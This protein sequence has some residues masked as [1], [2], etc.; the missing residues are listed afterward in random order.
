MGALP[1]SIKGRE[2]K[3]ARTGLTNATKSDWIRKFPGETS[4]KW[5]AEAIFL[6]GIHLDINRWS[7]DFVS[8]VGG[9]HLETGFVQGGEDVL[10]RHVLL[11]EGDRDTRAW[12]VENR[13]W[14]TGAPRRLRPLAISVCFAA[15]RSMSSA[16]MALFLCFADESELLA[17]RGACGSRR[18]AA[19]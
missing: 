12:L 13:W 10:G 16:V 2:L 8:T 7:F 15:S 5:L 17:R 14:L 11:A 1:V 19:G 4:K 6:G 18:G 3:S 9:A